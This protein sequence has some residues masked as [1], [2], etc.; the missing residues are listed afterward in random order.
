MRVVRSISLHGFYL[1]SAALD[2]VL[3]ASYL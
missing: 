2:V 3:V 1:Q